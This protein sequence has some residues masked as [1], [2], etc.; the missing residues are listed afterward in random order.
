MDYS[1]IIVPRGNSKAAVKARER[2]IH[3]Y[4][5]EWRR[6]HAEQ[7][8]FNIDLKDYIN[9]RQISMIET[10]EHASKSYLS[11]LAVLQLD[12]ILTYSKKVRETPKD[13]NSKNQEKFDRIILMEYTCPGIGMVKLT[14]GV[15]RRTRDKIQYCITSI[16]PET[17]KAPQKDA[18]LCPG[19]TQ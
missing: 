16:D 18:R 15:M 9:I 1:D 6:N 2:I 10:M 7:R 13:K 8:L 14:V 5:Q 12:A 3:D 4:Y 11:T 17:R 19:N